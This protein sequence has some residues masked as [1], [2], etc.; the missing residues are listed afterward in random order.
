MDF[1]EEE[2]EELGA[3]DKVRIFLESHGNTL[4]VIGEEGSGKKPKKAKKRA[5]NSTEQSNRTTSDR[6]AP[7]PLTLASLQKDMQMPVPSTFSRAQSPGLH[8]GLHNMPICIQLQPTK[9]S[10]L[11]LRQ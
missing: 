10:L 3:L 2:V 1:G 8:Q 9:P 11:S 6:T 7:E 4:G 5:A